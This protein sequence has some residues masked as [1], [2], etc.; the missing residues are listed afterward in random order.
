MMRCNITDRTL[1]A[2][3]PAPAGKQGHSFICL[4]RSALLLRAN[5]R[6][7]APDTHAT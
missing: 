4:S 7:A 5:D 6:E 3:K 1:K 2:I